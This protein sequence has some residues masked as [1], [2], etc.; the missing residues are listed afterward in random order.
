MREY[1]IIKGFSHELGLQTYTLFI[2]TL[3]FNEFIIKMEIK[4]KQTT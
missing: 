2:L 1:H 3:N 4:I